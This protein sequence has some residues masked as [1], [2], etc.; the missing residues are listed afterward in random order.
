MDF[1]GKVVIITGGSRGIGEAAAYAFAEAGAD[2][3]VI[4]RKAEAVEKVAQSISSRGVRGIGIAAHAGKVDEIKSAID[5]VA[6]DWGRVDILVNNAATNPHFGP[7]MDCT[8]SLWDKIFEVNVKG[9][10]LAAQA[11]MPY[12]EKTKGVIVNVASVA[13]LKPSPMMGVYSITK[14]AIIHMTKVLA[15]ELGE[16]DIR[17]NCVAPGVIRTRFSQAL[18]ENEGIMNEIMKAHA[19][20][21][22]GEPEEVA[23]AI[24]YLASPTAAYVTGSVV[25][26]DGGE[27]VF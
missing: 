5:K 1:Q 23:H 20:Q 11:A 27:L 9:Y 24:L 15:R 22:I 10:F 21:R 7:I 18:W 14:A 13:G 19:I 8:E 16:R 3:A 6:S 25:V 17:V 4:S 26:L 2:V 12:L